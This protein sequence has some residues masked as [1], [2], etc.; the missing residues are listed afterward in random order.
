MTRPSLPLLLVA[1]L[2]VAAPQQKGPGGAPTELEGKWVVEEATTLGGIPQPHLTDMVIVI[3]RDRYS[4]SA[5]A[6]SEGR[7][8]VDAKASPKRLEFEVLA[9]D[10][11]PAAAGTKGR[12][13]YELDGDEL[14]MASFTDAGGA[15]PD[16]FDPTDR[17]QM[18]WKAKRVK[19]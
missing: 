15:I 12:W 18:I 2:A 16:K 13:I 7:I 5:K 10:G 14:R 4:A 11:K 8:Q 17:R 3:K 1:G 9:I 19:N 6:V